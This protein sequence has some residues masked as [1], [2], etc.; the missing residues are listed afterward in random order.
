[1]P[2]GRREVALGGEGLPAGLYVVRLAAGEERA[3][4]RVVRVR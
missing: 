3:V 4:R 1:V 2:P